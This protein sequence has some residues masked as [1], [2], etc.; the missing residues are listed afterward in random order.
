MPEIKQARRE[1]RIIAIWMVLIVLMLGVA[2]WAWFSFNDSTNVE[3]IGSTISDTSLNLLIAN[4]RNGKYAAKCNL[5]YNTELETL[6]PVST[7]DLKS[8]YRVVMQDPDGIAMTYRDD[9]ANIN[10]KAIHGTVYLKCEGNCDVFF[11]KN[12]LKVTGDSQI[13]SAGRVGFRV[14]TSQGT[15][16]KILSLDSMGDTSGAESKRTVPQ[17]NVVVSQISGKGSPS[18]TADPAVSPQ[19]LYAGGTDKAPT[20]GKE[21]LCTMKK[22]EIATV[23]YFLYLEGC[24]DNCFNPVQNRNITLQLGFAGIIKGA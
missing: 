1:L 3:P 6:S 13:M 22:N 16:V 9:T 15:T 14:T 4:E 12:K 23:E 21:R 7:A 17:S 5:R 2:T 8:F 20:A 11:D 24:D 18:Y 19:R 10:K